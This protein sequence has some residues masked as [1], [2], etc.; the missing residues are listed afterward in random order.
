[1]S[2]TGPMVLWLLMRQQYLLY[3][4]GS[5]NTTS[6]IYGISISF[7]HFDALKSKN[8]ILILSI[9]E[10]ASSFSYFFLRN[11]TDQESED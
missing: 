10:S 3:L 9:Q 5:F 1:M 8:C 11:E 7:H 6:K 2:D 4:C